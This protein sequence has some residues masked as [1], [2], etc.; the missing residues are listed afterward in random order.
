VVWLERSRIG[1]GLPAILYF[2][3]SRFNIIL[4]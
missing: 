1:D 3:N 2:L 4:D